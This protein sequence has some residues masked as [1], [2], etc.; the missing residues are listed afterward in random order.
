MIAEA[1]KRAPRLR[2]VKTCPGLYM[3]ILSSTYTPE[4]TNMTLEN[5]EKPHLSIGNTS[6]NSGFSV[7]M[8]VF[9]G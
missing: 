4:F 7:V 1:S 6:S 2:F 5:L 8:L 9:G 3:G